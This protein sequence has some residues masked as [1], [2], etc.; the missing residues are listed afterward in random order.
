ML[1]YV[2]LNHNYG[3]D[4]CITHARNILKNGLSLPEKSQ[5][6]RLVDREVELVSLPPD[7]SILGQ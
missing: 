3:I 1:Q 5:Q 2:G 6:L 7:S 4:M